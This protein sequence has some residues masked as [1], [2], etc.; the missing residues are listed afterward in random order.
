MAKTAFQDVPDELK[1]LHRKSVQ[2][3]D[4]FIHGVVQSQRREMSKAQKRLLKRTANIHSPMQGRGSMFRFIS[5]YWHALTDAQRAAWKASAAYSALT[6]WQLFISDNAARF[7]NSVSFPG[8][9]SDVW[10]VRAGQ[11]VIESPAAEILLRQDHPQ[12][13]VV[14]QKVAGQTWKKEI[15][16]VVEVFGLPLTVGISYKSDLTPT[17][18]TQRARLY[19]DVLYSYQGVD[20][21]AYVEVNFD[22]STGWVADS[23]TLSS[24][25]GTLIGYTLYLDVYGYTGTLLFDNV[26]AEHGGTNWARDPRCD[27]ISKTF[28]N[29]FAMVPPYWSP[30]SLPSGASFSTV[31]PPS[32]A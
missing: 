12:A 17:G 9:P 16:E 20:R 15:V 30:D 10:Q 4:R 14:A 11:I 3:R 23:A 1:N 29:A 32:T 31:Y 21:H 18:G 5:P 24:V 22:P 19:A 7:K 6:N 26:R 8:T 25:R 28:E 27:D 2:N 13:Y